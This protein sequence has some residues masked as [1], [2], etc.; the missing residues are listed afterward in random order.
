MDED[1]N[2]IS[3]NWISRIGKYSENFK[4]LYAKRKGVEVILS[5]PLRF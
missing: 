3:Y 2:L 1:E 4:Y 5:S